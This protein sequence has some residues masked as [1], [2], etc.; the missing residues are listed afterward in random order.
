MKKFLALNLSDVV[1]IM[2]KNVK[3]PTIVRIL[4]FRRKI[5]FVLGS[6]EHGKFYNLGACS[7]TSTIAMS[8]ASHGKCQKSVLHKKKKRF[9]ISYEKP[10]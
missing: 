4:T 7:Y 2:L 1:Y 9:D 5:N 10:H 6:V 8:K 3:M